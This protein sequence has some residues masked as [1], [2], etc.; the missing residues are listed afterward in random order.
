MR[1]ITLASNLL[2]SSALLAQVFVHPL[3]ERVGDEA[4]AFYLNEKGEVVAQ[5]GDYAFRRDAFYNKKT[6]SYNIVVS[7]TQ[8]KLLSKAASDEID[9]IFTRFSDSYLSLNAD[10]DTL[11]YLPFK[12]G[13]ADGLYRKCFS[14]GKLQEEGNFEKGVK[15]GAWRFYDES[16]NLIATETYQEGI[17]NGIWNR[18]YPNGEIKVNKSFINGKVIGPETHYY[19]SGKTMALVVE[20]AK[21]DS[22]KTVRYYENG[23]QRE[24]GIYQGQLRHGKWEGRYE[25]GTLHYQGV[26]KNGKRTGNWLILAPTS[27]TL[28][29]GNYAEAGFTGFERGYSLSGKLVYEAKFDKGTSLPTTWYSESGECYAVRQ[30]GSGSFG[31]C[32]NT[33]D[34]FE[35]EWQTYPH[36]ESHFEEF[37][38]KTIVPERNKYEQHFG[39]YRMNVNRDGKVAQMKVVESAW[40]MLDEYIA[41]AIQSINWNTGTYFGYPAEYANEFSIYIDST[42]LQVKIGEWY[43]DDSLLLS[44]QG[45]HVPVSMN[46][47]DPIE[48]LPYFNGGMLA[49]GERIS[50]EMKYPKWAKENGLSGETIVSFTVE[51]SGILS[52][53]TVVKNASPAL[54]REALRITRNLPLWKSGVK[55][56]AKQRAVYNLPF[57]FTL[58]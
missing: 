54:D 20:D 2:F 27:D 47:I 7:N 19:E 23:M 34:R 44:Q 18:Y 41:G 25:N 56:G 33:E 26:Y 49:L 4:F 32:G 24:S 16:G 11:E 52:N 9:P 45:K 14:D 6:S 46:H 43:L 17:P 51:K 39:A 31:P 38:L 50:S 13:K 30:I 15:V 42:G 22:R 55:D 10:G 35:V 57:R 8:G 53:V 1:I 21:G 3:A 58:R 36:F 37:I 5:D 40:P 28:L 29:F 48:S 12:K